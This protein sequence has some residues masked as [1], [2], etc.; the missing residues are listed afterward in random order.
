MVWLFVAFRESLVALNQFETRC[1]S[2]FRCVNYNVYKMHVPDS[3][4]TLPNF[5]VSHLHWLPVRQRI[6]SKLLL[7]TYKTLRGLAPVYLSKLL[8]LKSSSQSY[9]FRSSHDTMLLSYPLRK[10]KITLGDRAFDSAARKL[11]NNLPPSI[12]YAS[13][14][15]LFNS[16]VSGNLYID[17][18]STLPGLIILLLQYD[19]I[20]VTI[21]LILLLFCY[22]QLS[23]FI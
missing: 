2:I 3:S 5:H 14:T 18:F 8:T 23:M 11:W 20:H 1:N 10:T 21:N 9:R 17:M 19:F 6:K 16:P 22:A 13:S 12:R 15:D 4:V 7:I